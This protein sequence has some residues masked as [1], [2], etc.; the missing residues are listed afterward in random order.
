MSFEWSES[1]QAAGWSLPAPYFYD[2]SIF[3]KERLR[4]F[5][6]S[7]HLVG[8][9]NEL[10]NPGD[11][12]THDILDQSVI[13]TRSKEGGIQAFHNVCQHRG[14]RLVDAPRGHVP[15]INPTATLR[16]TGLDP[17]SVANSTALVCVDNRLRGLS[18]SA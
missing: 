12:V 17:S 10:R 16:G 13:V 1:D 2:A 5:F 6:R 7:W 9:V 14:N 3:Q 4:I 18:L 8:H 11:F 15:A